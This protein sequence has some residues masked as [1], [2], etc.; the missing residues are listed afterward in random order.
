MKSTLVRLAR[1][2]PLVKRVLQVPLPA[3]SAL[4]RT[5][6]KRSDAVLRRA[7]DILVGDVI[8]KVKEFHGEFI[9][10]AKSDLF[11]RLLRHGFYEPAWSG[12]FLSFIKPGMDIIDVGANVGFYTVAAAKKGARV[13]AIEP[14]EG[15]FRRLQ[16]NVRRNGVEDSVVL[17][18]GLASDTEGEHELHVI[19]GKE[20]Y[21]SMAPIQPQYARGEGETIKARS[22]TLDSLAA[23]FGFNPGLIKVDTEGAELLVFTGASG[24]LA[25]DRPVVMSELSNTLLGGFG[26]T[27]DEVV[28]IFSDLGYSVGLADG[29]PLSAGVDGYGE[30][31]CLPGNKWSLESPME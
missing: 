8:V 25:K 4:Q 26:A 5:L 24:I 7:D 30:I 16:E 21:S 29:Q 31:L 3:Y 22:R 11:K 13:L 23:E 28:E 9:M 17:F 14:A 18:H 12:A 15:A 20:E 2:Y 27:G 10:S 19:E 1:Q 6:N